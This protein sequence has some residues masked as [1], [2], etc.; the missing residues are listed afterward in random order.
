MEE[1]PE[2][3]AG[4]WRLVRRIG[5]GGMGVVFQVVD[6]RT[7]RRCAMKVLSRGDGNLVERFRREASALV[8]I[9]SEHVVR[10]IEA[11]ILHEHGGRPYMVMEHL[12][13]RD[14]AQ[15]LGERTRFTPRETLT[16]LVQAARGV[17]CA[18]E[19]GIVHRDLKPENL[20]LHEEVDGRRVVKVVDFGLANDKGLSR[21]TLTG[22]ALGTPL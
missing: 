11:D 9:R 6:D 10:V 7:K 21:I 1:V 2:V 13:G 20:F 19:Q 18:H 22:E 8:R 17:A 5:R 15:W 12:R 3:L 16:I 4:R 14:V